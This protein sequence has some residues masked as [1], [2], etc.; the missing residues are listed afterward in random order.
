MLR[1]RI[2]V[3]G[4]GAG[5]LEPGKECS[6]YVVNREL[7][8]DLGWCGVLRMPSQ[9]ISPSQIKTVV[10][11]HGH[12]DHVL[13]LPQ[14]IYFNSLGS[15]PDGRPLEIVGRN[16]VVEPLVEAALAFVKGVTKRDDVTVTV[17][18]LS[19]G[20]TWENASYRLETC[21]MIHPFPGLCLRL[22]DLKSGAVLVFSGDTAYNKDLIQ[23]ARGADVLI[24]EGTLGARMPAGDKDGHCGGE[25]AARVAK[26]AGVSQLLLTHMPRARRL[27]ALTGAQRHFPAVA[28]L[29]DGDA[30]EVVHGY[31][32]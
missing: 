26:E 29:E 24:H 2:D 7:L 30:I 13:G 21:A 25:E 15:R 3:L 8:I 5:L 23:L 4:S 17:T 11:T 1:T 10:I 9:G 6:C 31:Q 32:G 22:T 14:L 28:L 16:G 19:P 27:P 12:A 18:S 20:E